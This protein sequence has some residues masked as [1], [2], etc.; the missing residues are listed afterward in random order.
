MRHKILSVLAGMVA[1][2][3]C[4]AQ[5]PFKTLTNLPGVETVFVGGP[6]LKLAGSMNVG[7]GIPGDAAKALTGL[8]V[9]SIEDVNSTRI[10]RKVVEQYVDSLRLDVLL[11]TRDEDQSVNIFGEIRGTHVVNP[12]IVTDDFSGEMNI[13]YMRGEF[14]FN[15]MGTLMQKRGTTASSVLDDLESVHE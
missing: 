14:D 5:N 12:V 4:C 7:P 11:T 2:V 1:V 3:S 10:A 15:Q 9:Y 6:M 8:G 13:I